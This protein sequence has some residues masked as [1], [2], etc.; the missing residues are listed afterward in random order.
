[1]I[2][3]MQYTTSWHDTNAARQVRPSALLVYMQETSNHHMSSCGLSLDELR[4]KYGLAFIVS[5]IRLEILAPLY[6]FE[7]ITV[8]TW[9][10]PYHALSIP[11]SFRILRGDEVIAAADTT[12]ALV[13]INTREFVR[14]EDCPVLRFEH[15]E[16]VSCDIPLRFKLPKGALCEKL[17]ERKI[18]WSDLDYNMHMNNTHYPDM[19]CDFLPTES[20]GKIRGFL[21]SYVNEAA[22]GQTLDVMRAESDGSF[23][24]RTLDPSGRVCLEAQVLLR[25]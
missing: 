4:D 21:L 12:W 3:T 2:F 15:E 14:G 18:V 10:S 20:I 8:Q 9:T 17:G 22:F 6:A 23:F 1:M 5:K 24:F 13:N 7:N 25:E 11:R 19:L 16:S